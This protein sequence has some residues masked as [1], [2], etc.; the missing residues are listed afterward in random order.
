[1]L[2]A[3][4]VLATYLKLSFVNKSSSLSFLMMKSWIK[5]TLHLKK[6]LLIPCLSILSRNHWR[7]NRRSVHVFSNGSILYSSDG[8][9]L[10]EFWMVFASDATQPISP[11]NLAVKRGR[12]KYLAIEMDGYHVTH[13]AG[14][15]NFPEILISKKLVESRFSFFINKIFASLQRELTVQ[16]RALSRPIVR[17]TVLRLV[18][19]VKEVTLA[20]EKSASVS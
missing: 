14:M 12:L 7:V 18:A 20:T 3:I 8:I 13:V 9:V 5:C 17:E 2:Q 10:I 6:N 16:W 11:L 19:F 1:M 4:Y 15:F